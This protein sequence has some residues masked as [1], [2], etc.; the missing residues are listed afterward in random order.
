MKCY[1][2][3]DKEAVAI[4]KSCGKGLCQECNVNVQRISYCRECLN[5]K[6]TL[7]DKDDI[8]LNIL[9]GPGAETEREFRAG[10]DGL[11]A[12]GIISLF[13]VVFVTITEFYNI[14]AA[15]A[16]AIIW[17]WIIAT[18]I[19]TSVTALGY[20]ALG[21]SYGNNV[22]IAGRILG[23][24]STVF[25]FLILLVWIVIYPNTVSSLDAI[26]A[27]NG[28]R[29]YFYLTFTLFGITQIV[30]GIAQITSRQHTGKTNLAISSRT[31]MIISGAVTALS[32][33]LYDGAL[34]PGLVV[35]AVSAFLSSAVF[36]TAKRPKIEN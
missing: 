31:M 24:I 23:Y 16:T 4:C 26:N 28:F 5:N 22:G 13:V 18:A 20:K 36:I 17:I 11:M 30:W 15:G 25:I 8:Q 1:D 14:Q 27:S 12:L 29:T 7:Q 21:T 19:A 6:L 2:H 32:I 10:A 34:V 9:F 33:F 3:P 35:F